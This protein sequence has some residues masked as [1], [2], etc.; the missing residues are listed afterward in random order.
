M[1]TTAELSPLRQDRL[2]RPV[3][4]CAAHVTSVDG[5]LH[6]GWQLDA[7]VDPLGVTNPST[8]AALNSLLHQEAEDVAWI[9]GA[10]AVPLRDGKGECETRGGLKRI[11]AL[12]RDIKKKR[13]VSGS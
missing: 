3:C 8:L 7:V 12:S 5:R 13:K 2:Q 4:L 1:F 9:L 6:G 11:G 10:S